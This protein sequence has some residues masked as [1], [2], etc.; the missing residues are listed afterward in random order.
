MSVAGFPLL[1]PGGTGQ[2]TAPEA[3]ERS[4]PKVFGPKNLVSSRLPEFVRTDHGLFV[5]FVEAYYE[6]LETF[7][8]GFYGVGVL[9]TAKDI[10]TTIDGFVSS[11]KTT[12]LNGFPEELAVGSD[13]QKL[14]RTKLLKNIREFYKDKGSEKG[15]SLLFRILMDLDVE[16][17]YPKKDILRASDGKWIEEKSLRVTSR[18][19]TSNFDMLNRTVKQYDRLTGEITAY[20]TVIRVLQFNI[21]QYD[22]TELFLKDIFGA[23][24]TNSDVECTTED[25]TVLEESVFSVIGSFSVLSGGKGYKVG[26]PVVFSTTS[27]GIGGVGEVLTTTPKGAIKTVGTKEFGVNYL[28]GEEVFVLS[29][30]GNGM[31]KVIVQV[32]ALC[33]YPGYWDNNDGKLSSNKKLFD[34]YF[35]QD[36][37]YALASEASIDRYKAAVLKLAH[38]TGLQMFGLV[39][40]LRDEDAGTDWFSMHNRYEI[41]RIGNYTPYRMGTTA[42]LWN[43]YG[44]GFNPLSV[45]G[46]ATQNDIR[47]LVTTS[48]TGGFTAGSIAAYDTLTESNGS[49]TNVLEFALYPVGATGST[50]G[51]VFGFSSGNG[52]TTGLTG[53]FGSGHTVQFV[54]V[55][56]GEGFIPEGASFDHDPSNA[57]LGTGGTAGATTYG[58]DYWYIYHHP[59]T[60]GIVGLAGGLTTGTGY[61]LSFGAMMLERVFQMPFGYVFH[62]DPGTGPY[63]GSTGTYNEYSTALGGGMTSPNIGE[64]PPC[65]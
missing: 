29:P 56:S 65:P 39:S 21:E 64:V 58:Q 55:F 43:G 17:Q 14:N 15:F 10:D 20:A 24:N 2:S 33:E 62:S 41:P 16:V 38:P 53:V 45:V 46:G 36:F 18:N 30:T 3:L 50:T 60:R 32:G 6:W 26:D 7:G 37:S 22:I 47:L 57:P 48:R 4:A 61:G 42:D 23:F 13:G 25:G 12:Y 11:F 54:G 35:Y 59:N 9:D 28:Q 44:C 19:G 34:G 1:F 52:F 51:M 8:G 27:G 49:L 5:A 40:F 31:A 63:M